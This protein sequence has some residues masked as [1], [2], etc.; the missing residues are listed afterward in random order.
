MFGELNDRTKFAHIQ[1]CAPDECAIDVRALHQ[2]GNVGGLD[3]AA[4]KN[5]RGFCSLRAMNLRDRFTERSCDVIGLVGRCSL[6]RPD[7]PNGLLGDD[8]VVLSIKGL[9]NFGELLHRNLC[10]PVGL[11]VLSGLADTDNRNQ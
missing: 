1:A 11:E 10:S 7:R 6:S 5:S 2:G 3:R 9:Q 4:I 8:V